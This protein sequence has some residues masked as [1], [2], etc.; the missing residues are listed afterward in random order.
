MTLIFFKRYFLWMLITLIGCQERKPDDDLPQDSINGLFLA[1]DKGFILEF[2]D[3]QDILYNIK[4]DIFR[5][6]IYPITKSK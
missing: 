4:L 1:A 6:S 3:G 2:K 5:Y